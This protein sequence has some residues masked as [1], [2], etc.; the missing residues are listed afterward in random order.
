MGIP[1]P[2]I[3]FN[4]CI[5][6]LSDVTGHPSFFPQDRRSIPEHFYVYGGD[7]TKYFRSFACAVIPA[8]GQYGTDDNSQHD[9]D[10]RNDQ[11]EYRSLQDIEHYALLCQ[12]GKACFQITHCLS[13]ALLFFGMSPAD[14]FSS[15]ES[16]R[17]WLSWRVDN[18]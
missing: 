8:Q 9:G 3:D 6:F 18:I 15:D 7:N 2:G 1:A 17:H 16:P 10:Q 11:S 14:P 13:P 5:L 4:I 12:N